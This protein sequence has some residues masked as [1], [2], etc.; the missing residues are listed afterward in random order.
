M[1]AVN[2]L[3]SAYIFTGFI[4][5]P[6]TGDFEPGS[7]K[8]VVRREFILE[9]SE[10]I[11]DHVFT[12]DVGKLLSSAPK[13]PKSD[14]VSNHGIAAAIKTKAGQKGKFEMAP[15]NLVLDATRMQGEKWKEY[16]KKALEHHATLD[17]RT[18]ITLKTRT[19]KVEHLERP[20]DAPSN[21]AEKEYKL[22]YDK[23]QDTNKTIIAFILPCVRFLYLATTSFIEEFKD[24]SILVKRNSDDSEKQ[25]EKQIAFREENNYSDATCAVL[26][27]FHQDVGKKLE[28]G[29]YTFE[30]DLSKLPM[31]VYS[32]IQDK[33]RD[34]NDDL[35]ILSSHVSFS[36]VVPGYEIASVRIDPIAIEE[37]L[38][39]Q[40]NHKYDTVNGIG[41]NA[42]PADIEGNELLKLYGSTI[43]W[44]KFVKEKESQY[45][46]IKKGEDKVK[47][48][49]IFY[50]IAKACIQ[51]DNI[52]PY[53]DKIV[54]Y[55]F[56]GI[57]LWGDYNDFRKTITASCEFAS[58]F[59]GIARA[60]RISEHG[61]DAVKTFLRNQQEISELTS[62]A[63][64]Y[65]DDY[66]D[67]W[68]KMATMADEVVEL[69]DLK[70]IKDTKKLRNLI[71]EKDFK[72]TS[73]D[74][75]DIA[76]SIAEM[77]MAIGAIA[78]SERE[79]T[80]RRDDLHLLFEAYEKC[81]GNGG[82]RDAM[83]ILEI[84]RKTVNAKRM[85]CNKAY[86]EM[87][88]ATV[89]LVLAIAEKIPVVQLPAMLIS[90]AKD[91]MSF[92]L[93]LYKSMFSCLD[94]MSTKGRM[95]RYVNNHLLQFFQSGYES[96]VNV[97]EIKYADRGDVPSELNAQFRLRAEAITGLFELIQSAGGRYDDIEIREFI[98]DFNIKEYIETF[99]LCKGDGWM[100]PDDMPFPMTLGDYWI[101]KQSLIRRAAVFLGKRIVSN[102]I[103][104][105]GLPAA[106]IAK[107]VTFKIEDNIT[108]PAN[109]K[110][111][112][113]QAK[114]P[115][116]FIDSGLDETNLVKMFQSLSLDYSDVE[117]DAIEDVLVYF[118]YDKNDDWKPIWV[119]QNN[120]FQVMAMRPLLQIRACVILKK[121]E[122]IIRN[123]DEK[124]H[125]NIVLPLTLQVFRN[126]L[127][128]DTEGPKYFR[129]SYTLNK[130]GE[131]ETDGNGLLSNEWE[132]KYHDEKRL[133]AVF[134]PH[135][136]FDGR[137]FSGIKPLSDSAKYE[138]IR[139]YPMF[140]KATI[141]DVATRYFCGPG[142][143]EGTFGHKK[144]EIPLHM[145]IARRQAR[146]LTDDEAKVYRKMCENEAFLSHQSN[147]AAPLPKIHTGW[148]H[149]RV[150]GLCLKNKSGGW[151]WFPDFDWSLPKLS[152]KKHIDFAWNKPF[153]MIVMLGIPELNLSY[154]NSA[155]TDYHKIPLNVQFH[156]KEAAFDTKG[157]TFI[158]NFH[159]LGKFNGGRMV[160][161][162]DVRDTAN[163]WGVHFKRD[164]DYIDSHEIKN[165]IIPFFD[166]EMNTKKDKTFPPI[167]GSNYFIYGA[168][169]KPS[170]PIK[171][172]A[173]ET[174]HVEALRPF[175]ELGGGRMF[176]NDTDYY[177]TVDDGP[178]G[179]YECD[180][181]LEL[182]NPR[183]HAGQ[184]PADFPRNMVRDERYMVHDAA[185]L[186]TMSSRSIMA[187]SIITGQ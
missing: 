31:D 70:D 55:G 78:D 115:I 138:W 18:P 38:L 110:Q 61:L 156:H 158:S 163:Y 103:W 154:I 64:E 88:D 136:E 187:E 183:Y 173:E 25:F 86:F 16:I 29:M 35:L 72:F 80:L 12:D 165:L 140:I 1:N 119:E 11:F 84:Y 53:V 182:P 116:H 172:S 112:D 168:H 167:T 111:A 59:R 82:G 10:G 131:N 102:A 42:K 180:I 151:S 162:Y 24:L 105:L 33:W 81:F 121:T 143:K 139:V 9:T 133:G 57:G 20:K 161:S 166:R 101:Y 96:Y 77:G 5:N 37:A 39:V 3:D 60:T 85:N 21:D 170:Y 171:K 157:P 114:F 120:R 176:H 152:Y 83:A 94:Y 93:D 95:S 47:I 113:F 186:V 32:D 87:L 48:V 150:I 7:L 108:V 141:K 36:E 90:L 2:K 181:S 51:E 147:D 142:V 6:E 50:G 52:P 28:N 149:P 4:T 62:K 127:V 128:K 178:N 34:L 184:L 17:T 122:D 19:L 134:Y 13:P 89:N 8:P 126:K 71:F 68:K 40:Y 97:S 132:E 14:E 100:Y 129:Y 179:K 124:K 74:G 58:D 123:Y 23:L 117:A 73:M 153:E 26:S 185:N 41:A 15:E 46:T 92:Q 56:S 67:E 44:A 146:G 104:S 159:F 69:E 27:S 63:V 54:G 137:Q 22:F 175:G 99:I 79:L 177:I 144:L 107:S 66:P 155:R 109:Y 45:K 43:K 49:E 98:K 125:S 135:Y 91:T 118:R 106:I 174:V 164:T 145:P 65:M 160:S 75:L 169:V 30:L 130:N 148:P 76:F